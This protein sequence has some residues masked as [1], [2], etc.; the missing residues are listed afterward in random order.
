MT[1]I[2]AKSFKFQIPETIKNEILSRTKEEIVSFEGEVTLSKHISDLFKTFKNIEN[3]IPEKLREFIKMALFLHDLGKVLPSFQIKRMNNKNYEPWDLIYEIPHSLFSIF[4]IN[5]EKLREKLKNDDYFNFIISAIAYHHW[6]EFFD[7]IILRTDDMFVKLCKKVKNEWE[8]KLLENLKTE[9]SD[10][11]DYFELIGLNEKGLNG[12]ING[13]SFINYAIPPYKIDYEPIRKLINKEWILISGFLQRCDHFASWCEEEGENFSN[14]EMEPPE[15][16]DVNSK[17]E[18]KIGKN[19][20][21]FKTLTDDIK[22]KNVIL[23][24][25]TGYGKTEFGFLWSSGNKF[26]YT[27]PL[28]SAVNQ[29]YERAKEVLSKNKIGLLHSDADVYLI[30]KEETPEAIKTYEFAKQLSYPVIVSTGDQFF[31]YAFRPPGYEK[32]FAVFS[33]SR[34][35]I[36]EVQAYD[37]K[38]CAIIV[39][40][41]E[42]IYKMGGRFLLMTATL[43]NFVEEKIKKLTGESIF[44]VINVY[45]KEKGNFKNIIKHKIK[46]ALIHNGDRKKDRKYELSEEQ[47]NA[48]INKAQ[49]GNRVLVILNTVSQAQYVYNELIKKANEELK[50]KIYLL[51]SR[52]TLEDKRKKEIELI[53]KEFNNPKPWDEN[54]GKILV[55]TQVVEASLDIDADVLFTEICPLDALVQRMGRVL[56]RYFY[57]DGKVLDKS[58][59]T[60]QDLISVFEVPYEPNVFV[61]VFSEGLQ[62]GKSV[63][64][65]DELIKIS[66]AWLYKRKEK[67]VKRLYEEMEKW[68]EEGEE[69]YEKKLEKFFNKEFFI[70]IDRITRDKKKSKK[71]KDSEISI[72]EKML[73]ENDWLKELEETEIKLSEY[74]KYLLVKCFYASLKKGGKYL[75]KFYE[76]LNILDAGW[77][78]DRKS[79]AQE[80]F[81]EIYDINVISY[82]KIKEITS[83]IEEFIQEENEKIKS[84]FFQGKRNKKINEVIEEIKKIQK[85]KF[86]RFKK[87]VL[88]K[89]VVSFPYRER[90]R[91]RLE[92]AFYKILDEIKGLDKE[93]ENRLKRWFSGIYVLDLEYDGEVGIKKVKQ[94]GKESFIE[95]GENT[96][97]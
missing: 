18:N 13:R 36:D 23:V 6:R 47:L 44:E 81:R 80:I 78:S 11:K 74:D 25:P 61:W 76:T 66:L 84:I 38:A 48:V 5:K 29:I 92:P 17:I 55:A 60:K 3:K 96:I 37:P 4:L 14:V 72:Y 69:E 87:K 1:K 32:I 12:I 28:R 49:S 82:K 67:D 30:E 77:M 85:E 7:L 20:W 27:L 97:I 93:W 62:S 8:N 52:F 91:E 95:H 33:Y 65:D 19:A 24:A 53:E 79:Q 94:K 88:S 70:L 68:K 45:E 31:P 59:N 10:F 58:R 16:N 51:H 9:L 26:F 56:R 15:L 75:S 41:I 83:K 86:T 63:V 40:F 54:Q 73:K 21:Q 90:L 35:I 42:W 2:L 71:K 22:N 57:R 34:L 43:P 46:I 64:Y 39:K 89:F 50:N